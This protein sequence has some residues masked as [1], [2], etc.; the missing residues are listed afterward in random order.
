V[1]R[2]QLAERVEEYKEIAATCDRIGF[3]LAAM[4]WRY[5]VDVLS[6]LDHPVTRKLLEEV[7]K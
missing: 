3:H 7:G 4:A 6:D 2:Q 1:T 5:R